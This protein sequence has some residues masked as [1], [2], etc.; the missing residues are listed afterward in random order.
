MFFPQYVVCNRTSGWLSTG[1]IHP[2]SCKMVTTEA[3]EDFEE[4]EVDVD[5]I[6]IT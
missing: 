5:M 1:L 4:G 2:D 3:S 6:M